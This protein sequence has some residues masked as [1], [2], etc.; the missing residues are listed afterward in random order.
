M[1][2]KN[3]ERFV[4]SPVG[5][6]DVYRHYFYDFGNF[7][8]IPEEHLWI[9]PFTT[10]DLY[11][12]NSKTSYQ[13]RETEVAVQVLQAQETTVTEKTELSDEM[14]RD[15][16]QDI[17]AGIS[18]QGGYETGVY[19][20]SGSASLDYGMHLATSN[21]EVR[22]QS[23]ELST[24]VSTETRR[25]VRTLTRES[26]EVRQQSSR[27]HKIENPTGGIINYEMRRKM[28]RI[29]IQVQHLGT[30]LCWQVYIDDPGDDLGLAELVH[31]AK[32]QDFD[33]TPPPD[34]APPSFDQ[35]ETDYVCNIPFS[36]N[37]DDYDDDDEYVKGAGDGD[38]IQ[39]EFKFTA[40][41]PKSG[42]E[43]KDAREVSFERTTTDH[44]SPS[45]WAT[46]YTVTD[47]GAGEF[48]VDLLEVNFEKQPAVKVTVKLIWGVKDDVR[49][50]A[51]AAYIRN[52]DTYNQKQ[53][54]EAQKA[55]V[56]ALRERIEFARSVVPRPSEDLRDEERTALFRRVLRELI[57]EVAG[58]ALHVAAEL[59]QTYFDVDAML[60]FVAPDW[61]NPRKRGNRG[62]LTMPLVAD[63]AK[64]K[65]AVPLGDSSLVRF[66][67][68]TANRR[69]DNYL[70]T[71]NS[72]PAALGSSIGW[73]LQLDGDQHRNA[74]LN[75]AWVKAVIP[76][77]PGEEAQALAW[78]RQEQVEGT[79]G[80]DADYLD[81]SGQ[82]VQKTD[83][84][85]QPLVDAGGQPVFKK[86]SEALD[87]LVAKVTALNSDADGMYLAGEKV[88]ENGFNPLPQGFKITDA[89]ALDVFAQWVE[90]V[91][92]NQIVPVLV[93]YP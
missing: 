60:Y 21:K 30:Q 73:I 89:N 90:V 53:Q 37:G 17:K 88:Y 45:K 61:W 56:D 23:R 25:S 2:V 86:V 77:R 35:M 69:D 55:M 47:R 82:R 91:P 19:H 41:S 76:I 40:P 50:A 26:V 80:L 28:Q 93:T 84:T 49:A 67:S 74:F 75:A 63:P 68:E 8:S 54:Q 59:V 32:P 9:A 22:K 58:P 13:F 10:V 72:D 15:S 79:D 65:E 3:E 6:L 11:E 87:E 64:P 27:R 14:Q 24:K 51:E 83:A 78:L 70:I 12:V 39:W 5:L 92:T 1:T 34:Q 38:G 42:Y 62:A 29:G 18:V 57:H 36:P 43:L 71:E 31:I 52:I 85:G 81:A 48:E 20:V 7:L 46:S 4:V 33:S 66:D 44:D 16:Q